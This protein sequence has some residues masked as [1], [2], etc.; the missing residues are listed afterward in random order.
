MPKKTLKWIHSMG[1]D[2]AIQP[3][4]R[5]HISHEEIKDQSSTIV[6]NHPSTHAIKPPIVSELFP[7]TPMPASKTFDELKQKMNSFTGCSLRL[8][9]TQLVFSDGNPNAPIM[10]IGEAPGA[11]EDRLGKPFV[12]MSGQLLDKMFKTVGLTRDENLYII[13]IVPWRPP[14]NRQPTSDEI[15]MCLP[16]VEEHI[17]IHKPKIIILVGGV[18]AKTILNTNEGIL[19]L[20]GSFKSYQCPID[21]R[22][23]PI[24]AT[25]H[26]A[27]LLRSPGKK[28]LVWNDLLILSEYIKQN[29][30]L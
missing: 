16:F 11:D 30:I 12:G 24:M 17:S 27:F 18:A 28:S 6:N 2:V 22:E 5:S 14:G 9:A 8:T 20:R 10:V 3:N 21:Q 19:K 29:Q 4:P 7:S 1:V 13:N 23:I 25:L 15:A 26:P